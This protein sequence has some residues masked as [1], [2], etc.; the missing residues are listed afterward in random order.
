[1]NGGGPVRV[2]LGCGCGV[3]GDSVGVWLGVA[4]VGASVVGAAPSAPAAVLP[5]PHAVAAARARNP[6]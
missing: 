5:P 1:V 2:G 4:P 3:R 6:R